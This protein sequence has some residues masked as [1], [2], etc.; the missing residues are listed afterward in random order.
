M[1]L[2][3]LHEELAGTAAQSLHL[4][5]LVHPN[6]R[7]IVEIRL[8]ARQ[9]ET[10]YGLGKFLDGCESTEQRSMVTEAVA[11]DRK[12]PNPEIQ[13]TDVLLKLRNRFF[14][15][16]IGAITQKISQPQTGE[17]E[18]LLLLREQMKLKEQKRLPLAPP[19]N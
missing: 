7:R 9:H 5:W 19:Q 15:R 14:D 12:I 1:K 17:E 6:V 4:D 13:L 11:E 3:L 18:R 2:L 10:W 8:A 16:Q